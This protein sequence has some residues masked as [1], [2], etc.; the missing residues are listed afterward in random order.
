MMAGA[1]RRP[2]R[3]LMSESYLSDFEARLTQQVSYLGKA[4]KLVSFAPGS[5]V[6]RAAF[7][8]P[9]GATFQRIWSSGRVPL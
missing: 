7:Q 4:A 2:L 1:V 5:Q 8:P 3:S 6:G 9:F